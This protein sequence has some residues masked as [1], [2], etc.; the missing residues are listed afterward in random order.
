MK[1]L[2][3]VLMFIPAAA[4]VL[5]AY[6]EARVTATTRGT[7]FR[8]IPIVI[9]LTV[10]GLSFVPQRLLGIDPASSVVLSRVMVGISILIACSGVFVRYAQRKSACWMAVGGVV[11]GVFWFFNR[12]IV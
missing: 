12:V 6:F 7:A 10:F 11:M 2:A 9:G 4:F 3:I 1:S 5:A 8:F